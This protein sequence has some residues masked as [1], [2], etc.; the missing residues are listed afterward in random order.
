MMQ[1]LQSQSTSALRRIPFKVVDETSLSPEDATGLTFSAAEI[2]VSKNGATAANSAGSVAEVG[3]GN[4]YYQ[5]TAGELDTL[6]FL[7][8]YV[9]KSPYSGSQTVEV[10][11]ITNTVLGA[12]VGP[13]TGDT[14][15]NSVY[16]ALRSMANGTDGITSGDLTKND[17]DGAGDFENVDDS[18]A[19]IAAI[20]AVGVVSLGATT[21]DTN[22]GQTTTT[23]VLPSSASSV[24]EQYRDCELITVSGAN[25]GRITPIKSYVGSTRTLTLPANR[26]LANACS[27]GDVIV[28][29]LGTARSIYT[30]GLETTSISSGAGSL[31]AKLTNKNGRKLFVKA[32]TQ[33]TL[34]VTPSG[35]N[36]NYKLTAWAAGTDGDSVTFRVLDPGTPSASLSVS[37]SGVAITA[38]L[39]TNGSSTITTTS[40][41]LVAAINNSIEA[42][43]LVYAE[44]TE[45]SVGGTVTALSVTNLSG[46]AASTGSDS[47]D[48]LS[49]ETPKATLGG[50][51]SA[52]TAGDIISLSPGVHK[53]T[54]TT[55]LPNYITIEGEGPQLTRI[56]LGVN[57]V[58]LFGSLFLNP[59]PNTLIRDLYIDGALCGAAAIYTGTNFTPPGRLHLEN[60]HI[61][62]RGYG[63]WAAGGTTNGSAIQKQNWTARNCRIKSGI[64]AW[65]MQ[66]SSAIRHESEIHDCHLEADDKWLGGSESSDTSANVYALLAADSDV[67]AD[68]VTCVAI[69]HH[70]NRTAY[71]V[72]AGSPTDVSRPARIMMANVRC[73]SEHTQATSPVR[74]TGVSSATEAVV[75][76]AAHGLA[77]D[78]LVW[79][80]GVN[81]TGAIVNVN[82]TCRVSDVTTD[83]FK[84]KDPQTGDYISTANGTYVDGGT[85][86]FR[87]WD[88]LSKWTGSLI[89]AGTGCA[90][91]PA[92]VETYYGE[93]ESRE[94]NIEHK[95]GILQGSESGHISY[96]STRP[97]E[98]LSRPYGRGWTA[99]HGYSTISNAVL[100]A[101]AGTP[102]YLSGPERPF[103]I[104]AAVSLPDKIDVHGH[105]NKTKVIFTGAGGADTTGFFSVT[106]R[107]LIEDVWLDDQ[108]SGGVSG[109]VVPSGAG[110]VIM[111]HV[112]ATVDFDGLRVASS[113]ASVATVENCRI[114]AGQNGLY[115]AGAAHLGYYVGDHPYVS[116]STAGISA[117]AGTKVKASHGIITGT[118]DDIY[119]T[120][121]GTV[122]YATESN[123]DSTNTTEASS[124]QI[125]AYEQ[126]ADAILDT[127][128]ETG[129]TMRQIL[130]IK[131]ALGFGKTSGLTTGSGTFVA[132]DINDTKNRVTAVVD[133]DGNRTSM[134][135]DGD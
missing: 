6:G 64:S 30:D 121:S 22:S 14:A 27:S 120:G 88:V 77:N 93:F 117:A 74:I 91:T 44:S 18:L 21:L 67:Y 99:R 24:D 36:N 54:G 70:K 4:Y 100:E 101:T 96:A 111:D 49:P 104:T 89:V 10:I 46:G 75:T 53:L 109:V 86:D 8:I 17:G 126:V 110:R 52:H 92:S 58:D 23:V 118:T 5:A 85:W 3:N 106:A 97:F 72:Q 83:T 119:A 114:V 35:S 102:V 124:G 116:G 43:K 9:D 128:I 25:A 123:Y 63:V 129:W 28:I 122:I 68:G 66:G 107:S 115:F 33:S 42:S 90:F 13:W 56:R 113:T 59:G 94:D 55:R 39:A 29:K 98:S 134:T 57:T 31:I 84:P 50:A 125:Y 132:R 133:S 20:T 108:T 105:K 16:G 65:A 82:R 41:E 61:R 135:L 131:N 80:Q 26:A 11:A 7:A 1:F 69:H 40:I 19:G 81:G 112:V 47:N 45:S 130:K 79:I 2:Q 38:N 37:V 32:G 78:N 71:S 62:A 73:Y 15:K 103:E 12:R 76:S 95:L 51:I 87:A 48:G 60:V 34:A 127:T